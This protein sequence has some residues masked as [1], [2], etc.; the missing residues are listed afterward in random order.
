MMNKIVEFE[1]RKYEVV[2]VE[3]ISNKPMHEIEIYRIKA[4]GQ[5]GARLQAWQRAGGAALNLVK[6]N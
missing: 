1:G 3:N 2:D 5:R 6:G 4:N